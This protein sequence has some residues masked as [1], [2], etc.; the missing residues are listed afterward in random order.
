MIRKD[1]ARNDIG[2]SFG[3]MLFQLF[4]FFLPLSFEQ[5][6][7]G[8]YFMSAHTSNA[9]AGG[10]ISLVARGS[11]CL[12]QRV[13]ASAKR[14]VRESRCHFTRGCKQPSYDSDAGLSLGAISFHRPSTLCLRISDSEESE[15]R[16]KGFCCQHS[17]CMSSLEVEKR[18]SVE[19]MP[20]RPMI[21]NSSANAHTQRFISFCCGKSRLA[22]LSP[23]APR[24]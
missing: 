9:N 12:S 10:R 17:R 22:G 14:A 18:S 7:K 21:L 24:K 19:L 3:F 6:K 16:R 11:G 2:I 5:G 13:L 4:P 1:L 15:G 8:E 23:F 20:T